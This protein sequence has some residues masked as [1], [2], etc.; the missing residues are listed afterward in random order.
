MATTVGQHSVAAF[1]SPINGTTPIDANTVRSNDNTVRLAYV[2]HD[3]DTGIH[4]QS[5]TLA[6]RPVAGTAGRKWITDESGVYTLWFDDGVNWHPVSSEAVAL[7]VLCT[8]ALNRGDVV[9]VVGWNNGQDLPEVAKVASS[10]DI[11]FA[12]MTQ[13]ATI[14]TMGYAINTGTLQD[15]D[16]AAFAVGNILYP[17]TTGGFTATKPT[18]GVYQPVAFVLRSNATN[19]VVYVEFSAPRIVEASTNTASTVVLRDGSGN[20]SAGTITASSLA[21]TLTTAAQPNITSVGTLS[22][23]TVSG[24]VTVDTNT[25]F[26]DST[27]NRVGLGTASPTERLHVV[28][29]GKFGTGAASNSQTLMVNTPSGTAAGLQLF[30]DANESW[31]MSNPASSTALAFSNSGTE[32]MRLDASGNLGLGVSPQAGWQ[33]TQKVFEIVGASTAQ[34]VAYVNGINIGS[35]YYVNSA[36]NSIY[37]FTG[38]SSARYTQ[39]TT[40]IH[41]WS[42]APSGTAGNAITFT[43]AMTLDASGSLLVGQTSS[44]SSVYRIETNNATDNRFGMNVGGVLTGALQATSNEMKLLAAG[45]SGVLT[46]QTAGTERARID[47]SGN[48]V[49]AAGN[50]SV[51]SGSVIYLSGLGG[52]AYLQESSGSLFLGAGGAGRVQV[53]A[54]G[55]LGLGVTP[56]ASWS[57]GF[58]AFQIAGQGAGVSASTS[59]SQ[60]WLSSNG[61]YNGTNWIYGNSAAAGQYQIDTN[62]HKWNIAASGTAGNTITFTQAMTLDASGNLGIGITPSERLHVAGNVFRHNDPT[63]SNGY[64]IDVSTTTTRLATLFGGS[65]FAI[66]TGASGTDRLFLD[67]SGNLG[68]GVTPSAW[69]SSY[70]VVDVGNSLGIIGSSSAADLYFNA[71]IDS[72]STFRYKQT[73][74]ASA[75]SLAQSQHRWFIAPSGTAGNAITFTQAMTLDASGQ[76]GV[77]TATP[78]RR[79]SVIGAAVPTY[80]N[81]G[82]GDNTSLVG[83]LL[84]GTTNPSNGQVLYDNSNNSMQLFTSGTERARIDASGNLALASGYMRVAGASAGAASTTTIG[85]TTATTVGAAGGASALPATPL[86]YIIAHVGTTQVK[87]PYYTA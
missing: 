47:A 25:L 42:T 71:Y 77:G 39:T 45:A 85:N 60:V 6:S 54:S 74:T 61:I 34:I 16:T 26:V 67:S 15:I 65:S 58:K 68:L 81:V 44:S 78:T 17:N 14:N 5:S 37:S 87:I 70:K 63:N 22:T 59:A 50:L 18:S 7:T 30:Q 9:K 73:A 56:S 46:F 79:L 3:A 51:A 4:V 10:S 52:N 12:V 53:N 69:N 20:F 75:Y 48:L 31:V 66:R 29:N 72:G 76:L 32:R 2:D 41:H 21:G 19:G 1:T 64:T 40:G 62:A 55:N 86:G 8:T 13:N 82:S 49:L 80:I 43:Q 11:A 35:N 27:N 83:L 24:N 23:L 28:G 33:S 38:Q 36:G 57:V 84:G